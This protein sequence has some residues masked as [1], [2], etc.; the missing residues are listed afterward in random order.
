ML[1]IFAIQDCAQH[2]L[3]LRVGLAKVEARHTQGVS[4]I[5]KQT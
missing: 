3:V 4:P 5:R 2:P 1:A